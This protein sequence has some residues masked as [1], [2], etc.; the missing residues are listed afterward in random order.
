MEDFLL[1]KRCQRGDKSA[2]EELITKY[3][4][5]LFKFLMKLSGD[6][7][8][9]ED[10]T[11]DTFVKIIRN[12]DRFDVYKKT[13]FSTYLITVAKN[14]FYDYLKRN[15]WHK[16]DID[17]EQYLSNEDLNVSLEEIVM[18]KID[19]EIA[20]EKLTNLSEDQ[21]IAITFRY[22]EELTLKEIAAIVEIEPKTIK[23]RIHNGIVKL[24]KLLEGSELNG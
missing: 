4:P 16:D 22:I 6:Y 5:I 13:S 20:L 7:H 14:C 17:I 11:Q 9:A 8:T 12:I 19:T 2:F 21:R 18:N 3:H 10:L 15:K 24:R 23:S 1:I